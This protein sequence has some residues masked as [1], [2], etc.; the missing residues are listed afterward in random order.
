ML[1]TS[2]RIPRILLHS[3]AAESGCQ[4]IRLP[5]AIIL[6]SSA[7]NSLLSVNLKFHFHKLEMQ[8]KH[9]LGQNPVITPPNH[10][11]S[12]K[13]SLPQISF[14]AEAAFESKENMA[15]DRGKGAHR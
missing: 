15:A 13:N 12:H 14:I 8:P 10:L 3:T 9:E 5:P 2:P 1:F 6:Q 11:P 7:R 4:P